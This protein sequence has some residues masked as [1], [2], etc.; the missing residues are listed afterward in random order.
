M[1]RRRLSEN[2]GLRLQE[3]YSTGHLLGDVE[4][5]RYNCADTEGSER[6]LYQPFERVTRRL[7]LAVKERYTK[8]K[9]KG[10]WRIPYGTV[11]VP[12]RTDSFLYQG[13]EVDFCNSNSQG[14]S[15]RITGPNRC[16]YDLAK[17]IRSPAISNTTKVPL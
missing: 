10:T 17:Q 4:D 14:T 11:Q 16:Y 1:L 7:G 12:A 15:H 6:S 3:P 13:S 2:Q 8:Y 5:H 9:K